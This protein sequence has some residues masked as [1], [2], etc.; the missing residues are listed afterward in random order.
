MAALAE[1]GIA[2]DIVP[3]RSLAESLVEALSELEI[4][5]ALLATAAGAR[6][7]L[8]SALRERGVSVDVLALYETIAEPLSAS[9]LEAAT[10]A[11]YIV[12]ASGS[13]VRFFLDALRARASGDQASLVNRP[14]A[15][16]GQPFEDTSPGRGEHQDGGADFSP[17]TRLVSIGPV[18][19]AALRENGLEPHVEAEQHDLD[20]LLSALV[21]DTAR[22]SG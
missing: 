15:R 1:R 2:A 13:S 11:D 4:R 5:H 20:G 8:P 14:R 16:A 12:F 9:V 10:S 18:T 7:T 22:G 17:E 21:A 6:E 19:S 3:E